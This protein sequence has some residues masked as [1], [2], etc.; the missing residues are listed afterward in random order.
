LHYDRVDDIVFDIDRLGLPPIRAVLV[1][2][3]RLGEAAAYRAIKE[4]QGIQAI[5]NSGNWNAIVLERNTFRRNNK[6]EVLSLKHFLGALNDSD[7]CA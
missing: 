2:E 5:V 4:F 6:V 1:S 3:Y 7:F